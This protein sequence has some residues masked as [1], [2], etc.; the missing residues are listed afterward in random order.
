MSDFQPIP[1]VVYIVKVLA[2]RDW[3]EDWLYA[4]Q[5]ETDPIPWL[6]GYGDRHM[7]RKALADFSEIVG[8]KFNP[9][10][11]TRTEWAVGKHKLHDGSWDFIQEFD[12]DETGAREL[13]QKCRAHALRVGSLLDR[14][15]L[16]RVVTDPLWVE[17]DEKETGDA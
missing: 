12:D 7:T 17:V 1:G 9:H 3:T 4:P 2:E 11:P 14:A 10:P 8:V 16:R 15:L 5:W 6:T 13:M